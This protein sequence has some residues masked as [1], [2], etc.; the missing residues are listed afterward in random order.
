M[1]FLLSKFF[2]R[3]PNIEKHGKWIKFFFFKKKTNKLKKLPDVFIEK[4][5]NWCI[6]GESFLVHAW[7]KTSH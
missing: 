2:L 7:T 1:P 3:M 4:K 5:I 6:L